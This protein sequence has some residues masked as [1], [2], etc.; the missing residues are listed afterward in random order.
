MAL[1]PSTSIALIPMVALRL[2]GSWAIAASLRFGAFD[3]GPNVTVKE[4]IGESDN[5]VGVTFGFDV[6]WVHT[7]GK[8]MH[9]RTT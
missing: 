2:D 1:T 6:V 9:A 8:P 7:V 5:E 4:A 3:M